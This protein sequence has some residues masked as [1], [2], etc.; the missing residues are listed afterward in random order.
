MDFSLLRVYK[1]TATV[2]AILSTSLLLPLIYSLYIG[3][4]AWK[5][6]LIPLLTVFV[7]FLPTLKIPLKEPSFKEALLSVVLVWFLFPAVVALVYIL[8]AHIRDPIN[9][10]FESVS[11]FTTT[12]ATILNNIEALKPSILLWRSFTQWLGGLGF[13]VFSFSI[14]PFLRS[15][16]HLLRFEASKIVEERLSP[17]ILKMVRGV[18]IAYSLLTVAEVVLLKLVG[19]SWYQAVNHAFTTVSTGGFSTKNESIKEFH[20]QAVEFVIALFMFLGSLNMVVYYR[21]FKERNP[22]KVFTYFETVSLFWVVTISTILGTFV[23]YFNHYYPSLW[24]DFRFALFQMVSAATT[25]GFASDDFS[26]YP[27]FVA[28]LMFGITLIG[29][30][31]GSTAGGIKQF[32]FVLLTK[33]SLAEIKKTVHPRLVVRISINGKVVDIN[34]LYGVLALGFI[35]TFTGVVFGI[36]LTLGGHDLV[37]SFS[38]SIACLTSFGPG[39]AKVGPMNNFNVFSDWQKLLLSVEMVMGRLEVLPFLGVIYLT[40]L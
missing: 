20:S 39:L 35:Y 12:G 29:G 8:G 13:I 33:A 18:L 30:S 36:L 10:Y 37:T 17:D 31:S 28:A 7:F 38:A 23:L 5:D 24:E 4:G 2:L 40:K 11:G 9:A 15:S 3:D 22:L 6:F 14:L 32:R 34:L 25:T 1:I 19:L 21:A 27:P 16:Y 26:L